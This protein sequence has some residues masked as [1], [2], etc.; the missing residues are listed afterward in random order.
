M[1]F[2]ESKHSAASAKIRAQPP[3]YGLLLFIRR[4]GRSIGRVVVFFWKFLAGMFLVQSL[5]GGIVIVG[6]TCRLMQ[7]AMLKRW[8]KQ[9][10]AFENRLSFEAFLAASRRTQSAVRWPNWMIDENR[11]DLSFTRP[12]ERWRRIFRKTFRALWLNF[13]LGFQAILNTW[14]LTLPPCLLWLFSWYDGW[15]NSFNKGYEQAPVGPLIGIAGV[16]LFIAVMFYLPMAQA[17][18]AATG[19][20]KSF[21]RFTLIWKLIRRRSLSCLLLAAAY[22]LLSLP[23]T[24]LLVMPAFLPQMKP[25]WANLPPAEA[26]KVLNSFMFWAGAAVLP[27]YVILR[28]L[29]ARIYAGALV[30]TFQK[31]AITEDELAEGEWEALHCLGLLTLRPQRPWPRFWR[32]IHWVGTRAGRVTVGVLTALVWFTF[33]SQI[34][35]AQFLNHH[36]VVGWLNQPLVQLPSFHYIPDT[37]KK[38]K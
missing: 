10:L 23:I 21:Y 29:A 38:A 24:I 25:A 19:N 34:Y 4:L 7:R 28:L 16:I 32:V 30:E 35:I 13:K 20:W 37:L 8:W 17:R 6:W 5:I 27:C 15:N 12:L 18:Q 26:L 3:S 36:P 2:E 31:G 33:V 1:N 11:L 14:V 9:S 22:S